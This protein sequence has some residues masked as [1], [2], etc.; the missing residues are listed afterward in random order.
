MPDLL[1]LLP[2]LKAARLPSQTYIFLPLLLGEAIAVG[3]GVRFSLEMFVLVHLFGLCIQ[4]YIVFAN[5]YADRETDRRN[6]TFTP[7]SGGSRVLVDGDLEP[8]Q[9]LMGAGILAVASVLVGGVISMASQAVLP[10]CLAMTGVLLLWMYS[11][12]PVRLSYRGGGEL[13]Q[14]IGVGIVLP[15]MGY[16]AFSGSVSD[17]PWAVLPIILP[18]QLACAVGTA[19]PDEPSDREDRKR[20]VP[21]LIGSIPARILVVAFHLLT[22]LQLLRLVAE[23]PESGWVLF[24]LGLLVAAISGQVALVRSKAGE[25]GT[26]LFTFLSVLSTLTGMG[27]LCL[28]FWA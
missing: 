5:D 26:V 25:K 10:V 22:T 7:F 24:C 3:Q 18:T 9:L 15:L 2:W 20:T 19:V 12:T 16:S 27:L 4:L 1:N 8:N 14:M 13:L 11:F 21:V 28:L 6:L 23:T 17:F